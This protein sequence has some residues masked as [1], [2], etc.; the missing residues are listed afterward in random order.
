MRWIRCTYCMN[1]HYALFQSGTHTVAN[2]PEQH[3]IILH[4]YLQWYYLQW[5]YIIRE[6]HYA[7]QNTTRPEW[8][9]YPQMA[10]DPNSISHTLHIQNST[11]HFVLSTC[12]STMPTQ[13]VYML[14][15]RLLRSLYEM[16]Y[17]R[18]CPVHWY[19]PSWC[20]VVVTSHISCHSKI[21]NLT[22]HDYDNVISK[23]MTI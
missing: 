21:S 16:Y 8:Y 6:V 12:A 5:S 9:W 13:N 23:N 10:C 14:I 1:G 3:I 17:L 19:L 2:L 4:M 18:S 15:I 11:H 7:M 22:L 20:V